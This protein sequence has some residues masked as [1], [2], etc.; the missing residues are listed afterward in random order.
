MFTKMEEKTE[1]QQS[2][3]DFLNNPVAAGF[4]WE[5]ATSYSQSDNEKIPTAFR[6]TI[7]GMRIAIT[8]GHIL[9]KGEW[10]MNCHTMSF[11]LYE[12]KVKTAHEAAEKAILICKT[13]LNQWIAAFNK[14]SNV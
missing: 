2:C 1:L 12:L 13:R 4:T 14:T 11:D 7:S 10:V 5:D 8:C 6:V 3:I 9:A